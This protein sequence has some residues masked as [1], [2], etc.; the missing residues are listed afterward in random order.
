MPTPGV[1]RKSGKQGLTSAICVR[2]AKKGLIAG[3]ERKG[4]REVPNG[5]LLRRY[6]ISIGTYC[7]V[8]IVT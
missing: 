3:S 5:V 4:A 7:K 8:I 6:Y 1:F 2:V